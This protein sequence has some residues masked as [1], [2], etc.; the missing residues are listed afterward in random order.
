MAV[1]QNRICS[2]NYRHHPRPYLKEISHTTSRIKE[3]TDHCHGDLG[4]TGLLVFKRKGVF[5]IRG[6]F[7]LGYASEIK[8]EKK[9]ILLERENKR[10]ETFGLKINKGLFNNIDEPY[11]ATNECYLSF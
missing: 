11:T 9:F 3:I 10:R 8:N 7:T 6:R 2:A 1:G 5:N 4:R